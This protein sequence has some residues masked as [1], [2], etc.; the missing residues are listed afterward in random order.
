MYNFLYDRRSAPMRTLGNILF[1]QDP[2]L[3]APARRISDLLGTTSIEVLRDQVNGITA[4]QNQAMVGVTTPVSSNWQ[5]GSNV[6]HDL[7]RVTP[8]ITLFAVYWAFSITSHLNIGHRHV[9]PTYP[10]IFIAIGFLGSWMV[11]RRW[12]L[13]AFTDESFGSPSSWR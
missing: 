6:S 5:A 3:L 7:Y 4:L 10:V 9:L 8:L 2:A 12:I 11:S 1:F 13:S